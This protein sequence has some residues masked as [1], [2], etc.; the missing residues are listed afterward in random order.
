MHLQRQA[1]CS[2]TR[3]VTGAEGPL[4]GNVKRRN[5]QVAARS[6][7][8]KRM[9]WNHAPRFITIMPALS[10]WARDSCSTQPWAWRSEGIRGLS[11]P[12][13]SPVSLACSV[14]CSTDAWHAAGVPLATGS[15]RPSQ[16][17]PT[18]C[19]ATQKVTGTAKARPQLR[20]P[21]TVPRGDY[22]GPQIQR[23]LSE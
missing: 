3:V 6:L 1:C 8:K 20:Y 12:Y 13:V 16:V 19:R 17:V 18:E 5:L 4:P 9:D 23:L 2:E 14:S 15:A 22:S 10:S 7:A 21:K 11:P